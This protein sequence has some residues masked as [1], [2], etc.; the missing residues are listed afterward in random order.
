M[1]SDQVF[2]GNAEVDGVPI[3]KL[4]PHLVKI[5][6]ADLAVFWVSSFFENVVPAGVGHVFGLYSERADLGAVDAFAL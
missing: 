5:V 6:L 3:L 4:M 2:G 1:V